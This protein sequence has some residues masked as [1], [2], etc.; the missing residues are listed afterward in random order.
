[1]EKIS[2]AATAVLLGGRMSDTEDTDNL[3]AYLY[4]ELIIGDMEE[5]ISKDRARLTSLQH[6]GA[7]DGTEADALYQRIAEAQRDLTGLK[8]AHRPLAN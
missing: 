1:A 5:A 7:G 6:A 2:P 8:K 3:L 4:E